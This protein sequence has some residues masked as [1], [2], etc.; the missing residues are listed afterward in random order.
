MSLLSNKKE[1]LREIVNILEEWTDDD[2]QQLL[3]Q[4]RMKRALRLARKID[5]GQKAKQVISE[6]EIADIVHG[7][8]TGK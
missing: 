1:T 6:Q 8:R 4:L 7:L 3:R 5:K 2:Q